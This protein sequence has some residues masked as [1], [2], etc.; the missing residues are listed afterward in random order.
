MPPEIASP[1]VRSADC[2]WPYITVYGAY[3]CKDTIRTITFLN[4][5][6]IPYTFVDIDNDLAGAQK[7]QAWNEGRLST[8]TLDI[9]GQIVHVPSNETLANILGIATDP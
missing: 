4:E 6:D 3:W 7:V 5:T 2:P 9:E 1:P 8:P